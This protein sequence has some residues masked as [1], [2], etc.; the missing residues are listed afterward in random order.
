MINPVYPTIISNAVTAGNLLAD[1]T[2]ANAFIAPVGIDFS[3]YRGDFIEIYSGT[4]LWAQAWI[5]AV[6]PVGDGA[7][8]ESLSGDELAGWNF[9]SGWTIAGGGSSVVDANTI[10]SGV[11]GG[12][13]YNASGL[14]AG[15]LYYT[16][17]AYSTTV[18]SVTIWDNAG[19]WWDVAG[20]RYHTRV[21]N[22]V[23]RL[24]SSVA[25]TID[26]TTM[27]RKQVLDPAATGALLLSTKGGS[28][29]WAYKHAS[30]DPNAAVTLRILARR[31]AS[32][33]GGYYK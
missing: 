19:N 10:I 8:G 17:F 29:G 21:G 30:F 28:R 23:F 31:I 1:T 9:T 26:V 33:N 25:A 2:T 11:V 6:A 16:E 14:V 7:G 15:K 22:E 32:G 3:R 18:G 27:S 20:T 13:I 4:T 5:S 24:Y 12:G